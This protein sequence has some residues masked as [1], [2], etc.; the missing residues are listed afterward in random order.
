MF[1]QAEDDLSCSVC[2][3]IFKD[4]VVLQCSH[5]FCKVCLQSWWYEKQVQM[6]PLCKEISSSSEP[7]CNL[8]LK[9]LCETFLLERGQKVP[10]ESEDLCHVHHEKLKLFC[11]DHQKPVCL[12]CRDSKAHSNHSFRPIDE[13]VCQHREELNG[14]LMLLKEKL[15]LFNEVKENFDQT[16]EYMKVQ[17]KRTEKQ[18]KDQFK[19]LHQFLQE[20]K[21][22]RISVLRKEERQKRTVLN[23]KIEALKEQISAMSEIIRT[24]EDELRAPDISFLQNYKTTKFGIQRRPL[25][26]YTKPVSG[27]LIEE[28]QHLGNLVHNIWIKMKNIV[29]FFPVIMDPNT[30]HPELF[31]SDDLTSVTFG[32]RQKLPDNP[33]RF[34]Q[35]CCVLGFEGF[36]SGTH[37]WDVEVRH[38]KCWGVG[39]IKESVLKKGEIQTGYWEVCLTHGKYEVLSPPLPDKTLSVKNLQRIRVQLD[40]NKGR[41]SFIDLDTNKVIH[42]FKHAFNEKLFP[43]FANNNESSLKILPSA[44]SET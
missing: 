26:D 23:Q 13:T 6:C 32:P 37:S 18:I 40:F 4:P 20:E 7:P 12:V 11:L 36:D 30:A 31:L 35:H 25:L 16:G 1:S 17:A 44:I 27:L 38:Y 41:L 8:A 33:E 15:H 29:S 14:Y 28:A 5:S 2:Q 43:Y 3:D 19:K 42:S 10:A 24:T 21:E 22:A 39:V 34:D 9:N